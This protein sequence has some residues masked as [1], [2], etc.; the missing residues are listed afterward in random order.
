MRDIEGN[1]IVE[2]FTLNFLGN[3]H[4]ILSHVS[5]RNENNLYQYLLHT[6]EQEKSKFNCSL[7]VYF[8]QQFKFKCVI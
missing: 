1:D 6:H 8:R 3:F 5:F 7:H 2:K 4:K